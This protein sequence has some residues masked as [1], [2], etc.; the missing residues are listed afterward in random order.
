MRRVPIILD[1]PP[2]RRVREPVLE[3]VLP[4]LLQDPLDVLL[5]NR[6]RLV[7]VDAL[8]LEEPLDGQARVV[9]R[10]DLSAGA[11]DGLDGGGGGARDGDGDGVVEVRGAA[12]EELDAVLYGADDARLDELLGGDGLGGV[13]AAV[14]DPL[15]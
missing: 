5:P 2:R 14:V 12:A 13:E 4:R 9:P 8:P 11:L 15:F 10:R 7:R 3:P 1:I 6:K